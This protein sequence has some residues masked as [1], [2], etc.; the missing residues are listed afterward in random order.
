[1]FA[2]I[3]ERTMSIRLGELLVLQGVLTS[4]QQGEILEIQ[5]E[6]GRPFGLIAEERFHVDPSAIEQAWA[7]QYAMIA[8]RIDP[9]DIEIQEDVL[10]LVSKRQAWQFGF[11][12]VASHDD[13]IQMVA[14]RETLARALRFVGW[15]ISELCTFA[16]CDLDCLRRGLETHYPLPGADVELVDRFMKNRPAA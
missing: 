15:R 4:E 6:S 7:A 9:A 14:S 11:I 5:R 8:Q 2:G 10:G 13:E 12:P 16:I 3:G 1:M